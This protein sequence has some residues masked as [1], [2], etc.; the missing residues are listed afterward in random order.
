V[1]VVHDHWEFDY[2]ALATHFVS[3]TLAFNNKVHI[4]YVT[5]ESAVV[6]VTHPNVTVVRLPLNCTAPMY[7]RVRAM[8]AYVHSSAFTAH[9]VFLDT[10]AY[11]NRA[12]NGVFKKDF[13]VGVTYRTT[14]GYMPIN[15]GVIYAAHWRP[16]AV[17]RFFTGYLGTYEVL[18]ADAVVLD[19]YG[20][21]IDRWRGGQLSLNAV[22]LPPDSHEYRDFECAGGR[23]GLLPCNRFNY[24]VTRAVD[25]QR[26]TWDEKFVLHLK[27]NHKNLLG[28]LIDYQFG[29]RL[30]A[31]AAAAA[32]WQ[33]LERSVA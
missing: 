4:Y 16:E 11:P 26:P 33:R 3:A 23:V 8:A 7:E 20:N 17:R 18:R 2:K 30:P 10:D 22:G 27:G 31:A 9:T 29:R 21:N 25:L 6:P 5:S 1:D 14:P 13:D 19:Y 32:N 28:H 15:E 24:S 12:L